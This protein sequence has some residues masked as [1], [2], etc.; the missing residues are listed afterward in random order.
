MLFSAARVI[1]IHVPK[2]AGNHFTRRFLR[3]SDD[4]LVTGGTRDGIDRFELVGPQ[5]QSKHQTLAQYVARL[6][7]RMGEYTVYATA[8]RP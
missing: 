2:T 5:T 1:F 7:S 3:Y 8:R 6:G 4:R